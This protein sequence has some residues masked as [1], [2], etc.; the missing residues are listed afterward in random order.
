M[1]KT[2]AAKDRSTGKEN[3]QKAW[4]GYAVDGDIGVVDETRESKSSGQGTTS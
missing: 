1:A 3:G 4:V 2:L